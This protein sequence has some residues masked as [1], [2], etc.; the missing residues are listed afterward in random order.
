MHARFHAPNLVADRGLVE[1][2]TDE[3]DHLGRVLRLRVGAEVRLFDGQGRER[4][5]V[6]ER[7]ER[8]LAVVRVTGEATPAGE[9]SVSLVLAQAVLKGDA[10]D[11]VVRDSVMIGVSAIV[12]VLSARSEVDPAKLRASGRVDRWQRIALASVKQ[13][14]RAVLPRVHE[15]RTLDACLHEF[16]AP[17][18][19]LLAE[20]RLFVAAPV[21]VRTLASQP[22]PASAL[23]LVGP[24]GGWTDDEVVLATLA[25]CTPITLGPRTLRADAAALVGMVALQC[26][27]GDLDPVAPG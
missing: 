9:A 3:A 14:G 25:G 16:E 20:P 12:P 17:R 23:L 11:E 7:V 19:Y 4:M 26:V 13:C 24:E 21:G 15:P 6:V 1:L 22:P 2:P 5:G 18:R 10:M 8:N 27:W